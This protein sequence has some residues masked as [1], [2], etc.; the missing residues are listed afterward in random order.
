MKKF[1]LLIIIMILSTISCFAFPMYFG[2]FP[3]DLDWDMTVDECKAKY[4]DIKDC[5]DSLIYSIYQ[6]TVDKDMFFYLYFYDKKLY[7]VSYANALLSNKEATYWYFDFLKIY[8]NSLGSDYLANSDEPPVIT[9]KINKDCIMQL[10]KTSRPDENPNM[11]CSV[12]IRYINPRVEGYIKYMQA[13]ELDA[14]L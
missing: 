5:S 2:V 14:F 3:I 12:Q 8:T 1:V 11:N 13:F 9:W 6:L 7:K 4:N 10:V